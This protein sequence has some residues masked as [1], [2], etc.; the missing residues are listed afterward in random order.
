MTTFA[1][2]FTI[3][4]LA[5]LAVAPVATASG[6]GAGLG[7]PI[8]VDWSTKRTAKEADI[9]KQR[10]SAIERARHSAEAGWTRP[11]VLTKA[12]RLA[13]A[14]SKGTR[15]TA[16]EAE[17]RKTRGSVAAAMEKVLGAP[18]GKISNDKEL[19]DA[20]T[21]E[22]IDKL[23]HYHPGKSLAEIVAQA[24][25]FDAAMRDDPV[26]GRELLLAAYASLAPEH[27]A[28]FKPAEKV[29]GLKGSLQRARQAQA[30]AEELRAAQE[31]WGAHLPNILQ[32]LERFD[33]N[34]R[35]DPVGTSARIA[36]SQGAPV[37]ERQVPAYEKKQAEKR[38]AAEHQR[39][40]ENMHRGV[41][42]AIKGGHL[43]SDESTLNEI[44]TILKDPD[45][46]RHLQ[47]YPV[48]NDFEKLKRAAWFAQH[49]DRVWL[50]GGKRPGRNGPRGGRDPGAMSISGSAPGAGHTASRSQGGVRDA[51]NAAFAR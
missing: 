16:S 22:A 45:F 8:S 1:K 4:P 12:E 20:N 29:A 27:F 17:R 15:E 37:T 48:K 23:R 14:K 25:K 33:E 51:I 49:P 44:A 30:D 19:F 21:R 40:Q 50:S 3:A 32:Q 7:A 42:E 24:E 26:A 2:P 38:A 13:L 34:L 18:S 9:R 36:A 35:L 31:K 11:G 5:P 10:R 41:V 46:H 28:K 43:P 47:D 39:R 6:G